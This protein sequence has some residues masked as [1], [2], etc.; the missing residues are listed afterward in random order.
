VAA[1]LLLREP[2]SGATALSLSAGHGV[3]TSDI[4]ALALG[5]SAVG[6]ARR[7][8]SPTGGD[9]GVRA[10][11]R[12]AVPAAALLVGALLVLVAVTHVVGRGPL[13]PAG[14]GTV[15]GGINYASGRSALPLDDW[16]HLAV[17]Y[18]GSALRLFVDGS[19]VSR[20]GATGAVP[21]TESPLW[22]G[23]NQP[24][25]EHFEGVIDEV[26][27][28]DR[29]LDLGEMRDEMAT[30]VHHDPSRADLALRRTGIALRR[31]LVAAYPFS[32]G[33]GRVA[34]DTSGH[35][36]A[37]RITGATWT[38][39]GR[40]GSALRFDGTND[41]VRVPAAPSLDLGDAFTL[42]AWIRPTAPRDGWRTI[43]YRQT[44]AYFLDAGSDLEA[45]VWPASDALADLIL[46]VGLGFA[47]AVVSTRG[48]RD[49]TSGPSWAIGWTTG[50]VVLAVG[51]VIDSTMT[52][53]A[54]VIGPLALATWWA[55]TTSPRRVAALGWLVA[56]ALA[57]LTVVAVVDA[58]AL[59]ALGAR[60]GGAVARSAA[61]GVTLVAIG[62]AEAV[63][64]AARARSA[65]RFRGSSAGLQLAFSAPPQ[66]NVTGR[67]CAPLH[68]PGTAERTDR[69]GDESGDE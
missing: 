21:R 62:T 12:L 9:T 48:Q 55:A 14:G 1:V 68:E 44:D 54:T 41:L 4:L 34:A 30:P 36:N 15:A 31:G 42:A 18:D 24:F 57:G 33:V 39:G 47:V 63:V 58:D 22:I 11:R 60:E 17:T 25:A 69:A 35:R 29:A 56:V 8:A 38:T 20:Q 23:G 51:L 64:Q 16:S 43:V 40:F 3:G 19:P 53:S 2:W 10:G 13:V 7:H 45:A 27:V 59:G 6:V 5:A 49:A 46:L 65:R 28:F 52:P 50:L 37:G 61:L 66:T 26:R 67:L 32:E